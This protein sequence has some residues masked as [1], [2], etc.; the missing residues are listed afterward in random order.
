MNDYLTTE[1]DLQV[2]RLYNLTYEEVL[3]VEPEFA[4]PK[5]AYETHLSLQE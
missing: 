5:E 2:Y 4:L 1:I 3:L